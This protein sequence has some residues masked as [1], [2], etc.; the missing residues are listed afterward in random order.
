MSVI[1]LR[2]GQACSVCGSTTGLPHAT[3]RD[4]QGASEREPRET[5]ERPDGGPVRRIT[6]VKRLKSIRKRA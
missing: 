6:T 1:R 2:A 3:L 4:C 5:I